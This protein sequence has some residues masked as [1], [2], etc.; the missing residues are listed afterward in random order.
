M[1]SQV[2]G[3]PLEMV[4]ITIVLELTSLMFFLTG[5]WALSLK[6]SSSDGVSLPAQIFP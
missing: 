1:K 4:T 2:L 3:S 5:A 6:A